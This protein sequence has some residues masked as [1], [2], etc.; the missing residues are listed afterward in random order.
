MCVLKSAVLFADDLSLLCWQMLLE[1]FNWE[2]E[3]TVLQRESVH[4]MST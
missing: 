4:D 3:R 1:Q 2:F